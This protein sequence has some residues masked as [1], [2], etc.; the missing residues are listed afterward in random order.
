M[1]DVPVCLKLGHPLGLAPGDK[2]SAQ[3]FAVAFGKN[4]SDFTNELLGGDSHP[5]TPTLTIGMAPEL[6]REAARGMTDPNRR[7][8]RACT[9]CKFHIPASVATREIGFTFGIC[10]AMGTL[11]PTRDIT[12]RPKVCQRGQIGPERTSTDGLILEDGYTT[13][14][15]ITSKPGKK[16]SSYD[17]TF[18][19]SVDPRE[20]VSERDVTDRESLLGIRA[21]RKV[22]HPQNEFPP[23]W[24]PIFDW[25]KL[26]DED[27]RKT[28]GRHA[29]KQYVDFTGNLYKFAMASCQEIATFS[30]PNRPE[31]PIKRTLCL[32]GE[33]GTG[34]NEFWCWIAW[35][36]DLPF[37]RVSFAPETDGSDIVGNG[38]LTVDPAT[39][40]SI[41]GFKM[42]QFSACYELPGVTLLDEL[43]SANDDIWY[44]FRPILDQGDQLVVKSANMLIKR[45]PCQFIGMAMNPPGPNY[46]GTRV[47]SPAD[48]RRFLASVLEWPDEDDEKGIIRGHCERSGYPIAE[49]VLNTVM[50]I[51]TALRGMYR[52]K[53]ISYPWGVSENVGVAQLLPFLS[54]E[55]AYRMVVANKLNQ[56][57]SETII[58]LI[59]EL[60]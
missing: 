18:H 47:L 44:H 49:N 28:Y 7:E 15:T 46:R 3:R 8:P 45:D 48:Q 50:A 42:G 20:W 24:M 6:A 4:C 22:E 11:V 60:V 43:N 34:K 57:Q 27:P 37:N 31:S 59:R 14:V 17:P 55:D 9:D 30:R 39:G 40:Q 33:A 53:A 23:L 58:S 21:W 2:N 25:K 13:E 52:D 41:T 51:S 12:T 19:S 32:I 38:S 26:V 1:G 35:L 16:S 10:G 29:P 56:G 36:M 5:Q 54:L